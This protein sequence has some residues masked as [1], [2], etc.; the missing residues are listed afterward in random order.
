MPKISDEQKAKRRQII[1]DSAYEVFGQKGYSEASIDDIVR[2]SGI[3]KGGI[4][5]YFP[6][7]EAILLE[8]AE[9]RFRVRNELVKSLQQKKTASE[10]IE[11]YICWLLEALNE[12]QIIKGAKFTFEFW[13]ILTRNPEKAYLAGERYQ[14]F[15][16]D[17]GSLIQSGVETGEFRKDLKVKSAVLHLLSGL[18]GMGFMGTVMEVPISK[19]DIQEFVNLYL[20]YWRA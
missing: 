20:H 4:Y 13:T 19:E 6:T 15:E 12:P 2:R 16:A 18:D 8:I 17:L 3:S 1:V 7:K 14:R 5:T 10:K 11:G 9:Q